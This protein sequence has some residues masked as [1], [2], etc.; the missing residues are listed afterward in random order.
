MAIPATDA[1][2]LHGFNHVMEFAVN[3]KAASQAANRR[4][5]TCCAYRSQ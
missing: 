3:A 4:N 2:D 5:A 1:T